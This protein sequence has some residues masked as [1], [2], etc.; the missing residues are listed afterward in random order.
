MG[1]VPFD[2]ELHSAEASFVDYEALENKF[3]RKLSIGRAMGGD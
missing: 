3:G 1:L 2:A